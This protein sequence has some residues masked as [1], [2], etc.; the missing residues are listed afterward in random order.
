M[1]EGVFDMSVLVLVC[2]FLEKKDVECEGALE[3]VG[4]LDVKDGVLDN[5]GVLVFLSSFSVCFADRNPNAPREAI[6]TAGFARH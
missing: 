2:L 1:L 3:V 6:L 5:A 4:A